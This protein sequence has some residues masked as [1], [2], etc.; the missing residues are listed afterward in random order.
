MKKRPEDFIG[1]KSK[2]GKLEVIDIIER[3]VSN[4]KYKVVC[5]ECIKDK[6]LFPSGY[7]IST[8][9]WLRSE[10]K[11]CGC[12][13]QHRWTAEQYLIL[14]RRAA[15]DKFII[16]GYVEDFNGNSTRVKCE[17]PIDGNIWYVKLYHIISSKSGCNV[18]SVA[19]RTNIIKTPYD[20]VIKNCLKICQWCGYDF[21][22]FENG[23]QNNKSKFNYIC[24]IHGI[25]QVAYNLF[26]NKGSRCPLCTVYGYKEDMAGY[27][28][29]YKWDHDI[30]DSFIKFGI[31]NRNLKSRI[32]EQA[33][34][35]EYK[36]ALVICK[37][38]ADGKIPKKIE[39]E[40]KDTIQPLSVVSKEVFP[41]GFTETT[42]Y[43]NLENILKILQK[44]DNEIS[45]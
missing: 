14:A 37:K 9:Q 7:F 24:P 28:Y 31:T 3:K 11:P 19:S 45:D 5:S 16:H 27:F 23:Y 32:R 39:D 20:T 21:I 29:V 1:W 8:R 44:Y 40:I 25:Q 36:P 43:Y 38:F 42:H 26:V 18:C 30:L 4:T 10:R 17:C 2:D 15:N 34:H 41:D 35:T 13:K 12:S 22:G 33:K 6:E